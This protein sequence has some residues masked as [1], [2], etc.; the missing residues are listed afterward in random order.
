VGSYPLLGSPH[1]HQ[2]SDVLETVNH[3]LVTEVAKFDTAAG[4]KWVASGRAVNTRGLASW[5][6]ANVVV[7]MTAGE[8]R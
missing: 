5:D 2:P 3:Q 4:D 6:E 1:Y 7:D 8:K